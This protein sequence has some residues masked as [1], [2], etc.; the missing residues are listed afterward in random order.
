MTYLVNNDRTQRTLA[1]KK[2][3]AYQHI[4]QAFAN[5]L[6]TYL[7]PPFYDKPKDGE[8]EQMFNAQ[9]AFVVTILCLVSK[10]QSFRDYI[11][12]SVNTKGQKVKKILAQ[13]L[14][15]LGTEADFLQNLIDLQFD[16][17]REWQQHN[18]VTQDKR[19]NKYVMD[20]TPNKNAINTVK[21]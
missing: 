2:Q 15:I 10:D 4:H 5:E 3:E 7:E 14:L 6:L 11:H 16:L 9:S 20:L 12:V 19:I 17:H 21:K 8:T 13:R 1:L 18:G